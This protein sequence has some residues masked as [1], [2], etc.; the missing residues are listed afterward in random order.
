[1]TAKEFLN[2]LANGPADAVQ[3]LLEVL[4][5]TGASY[6]LIGGLAVNAYA[7][8]VVSLDLDIVI[9]GEGVE[10]IRASAAAKGFSIE[11]FEH[12]VK[13]SRSDSDLR[14]QIQTDPRYQAFIPRAVMRTV[15]GYPMN[16]AALEDVLQGKMWAYSDLQ[17]RRSK[18]QK[19]L[20]DI[21]RLVE[22]NPALEA[23][24]PAHV[25]EAIK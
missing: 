7:E 22:V 15:L 25:R 1:M 10:C 6:C 14:I 16:V 3:L 5:E 9:A 21:I 17:R 20:A 23:G 4:A 18:R 24:L 13:L 19:D 8:P 11:R 2:A 12:S